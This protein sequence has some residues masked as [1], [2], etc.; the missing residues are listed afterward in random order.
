MRRVFKY[1]L[2]PHGRV[3]MPKGA[4]VLCVQS[5]HEAIFL[6]AEVDPE[7][8]MILRKFEVYG[9]GHEL[10]NKPEHYVGTV[11]LAGGA[12]VF[13]VYTDRVEHPLSKIWASR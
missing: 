5:Q 1:L 13:H 12:L 11:Q 8:P 2:E 7:A 6:R 10:I 3:E 4:A 9:T